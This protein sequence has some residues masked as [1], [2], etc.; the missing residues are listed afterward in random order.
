MV[1]V[2]LI[3]IRNLRRIALQLLCKKVVAVS[4][5]LIIIVCHVDVVVVV[6]VHDS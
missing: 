1:T 6:V 3:A 2:L 4:I 5:I